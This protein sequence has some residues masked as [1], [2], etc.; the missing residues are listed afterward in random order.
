MRAA[1]FPPRSSPNF[2]KTANGNASQARRCWMASIRSKDRCNRFK[3]VPP[4]LP[5]YP[6][7]RAGNLSRSGQRRPEAAGRTEGNRME[8]GQSANARTGAGELASF[9]WDTGVT[10]FE[11]VEDY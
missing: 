2:L 11:D 5:R 3:L 9:L 6:S 1:R 8:N 4:R 7:L 10:L